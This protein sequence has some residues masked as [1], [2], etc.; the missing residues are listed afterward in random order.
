MD[1]VW[2][3]IGGVRLTGGAASIA[4][5]LLAGLLFAVLWTSDRKKRTGGEKLSAGDRV[6]AAGF[7]LLPAIM[8]R[9]GFENLGP[10]LLGAKVAEPLPL[11]PWLTEEG[12]FVPC[13]IE[14]AAAVLCFAG[15]CLW[16]ILRREDLPGN[17]DL[18][19][20][21]LS[22]W[23]AVRIVTES[24]RQ[25]PVSILRYV[26]SAVILGCLAWWTVR[27]NRVCR[28]PGRTAADW[29]TVL[30]CIAMLTVS[31]EGILSAGSAV[32]DL[33]VVTGCV[34]LAEMMTLIAGSDCRRLLRTV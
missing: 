21:V 34:I 31:A 26:C 14:L 6:N 20:T 25:E 11:I 18:A 8:I 10:A 16:L 22:L 13:R 4:A 33:A 17:G 19:A 12:R 9:K 28:A 3:E 1:E 24:M 15:V 27:R 7:G 30:I 32:G 5:A 23:A 2:A 29:I